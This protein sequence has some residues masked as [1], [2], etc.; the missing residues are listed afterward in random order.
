[1]LRAVTSIVFSSDGN[2]TRELA[3]VTFGFR[4]RVAAVTLLHVKK[5]PDL[6]H[7]SIWGSQ[8][9]FELLSGSADSDGELSMAD[10]MWHYVTLH[11]RRRAQASGWQMQVDKQRPVVT[12]AG[13]AG[14]LGF[15]KENTDVHVGSHAGDS[16]WGLHGCLH[17]IKINGITL[18]L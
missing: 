11:D 15:L 8:L 16:T 1:M 7:V 3:Y 6:A 10:S 14:S 12:S 9:R 2:I 13:T 18:L 4:T 5:G 17:T